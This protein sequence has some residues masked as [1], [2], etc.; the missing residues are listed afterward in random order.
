[1][2]LHNQQKK[3]EKEQNPGRNN[4]L[5]N[6]SHGYLT[7]RDLVLRHQEALKQFQSKKN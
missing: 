6:F 4:I 2:E 7:Q 3:Q 5:T 1:M